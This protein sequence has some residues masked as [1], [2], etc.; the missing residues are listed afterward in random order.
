MRVIGKHPRT[1]PQ[2]RSDEMKNVRIECL[3]TIQQH[4]VQFFGKIMRPASLAKKRKHF[5]NGRNRWFFVFPRS[6]KDLREDRQ[7]A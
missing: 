1:R 7:S 5:T 3:R 6:F 2:T 4:E